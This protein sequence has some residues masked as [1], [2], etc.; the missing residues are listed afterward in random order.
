M[1]VG[2]E[3]VTQSVSEDGAVDKAIHEMARFYILGGRD[4]AAYLS[5][6]LP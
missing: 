3:N 5:T 2:S 4:P 1:K 6:G